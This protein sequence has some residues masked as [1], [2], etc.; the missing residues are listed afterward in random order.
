MPDPA[1][2]QQ[3][4]SGQTS[5]AAGSSLVTQVVRVMGLQGNQDARSQGLDCINRVRIE[6]NQ[7][8]WRFMKVTQSPITLA[9]GT[10]TYALDSAFRKPSFA[11]YI[12]SSGNK[13]IDLIYYD[14]AVF[15]HLNPTQQDTGDAS[16]YTL[17]NDFNDG[18]ISVYPVPDVKTA[19][20]SRLSVE[21]FARINAIADTSS[22]INLPEEAQNL[23]VIGGQAY[24]LRERDKANPTTTVAFQDYMRM[25][26][27]LLS[28]DRRQTDERPRFTIGRQ[29]IP[30]QGQL[31][32]RVV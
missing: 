6:M 17:R 11:G 27:L 18:F 15:S 14:D 5:V 12:D 13:R 1:I 25:V 26:G 31:F 4:G 32:V 19:S 3:T 7:H 21:Y 20:N 22:P 29:R 24:F 28:N 9:S 16:I 10:A 8:D 2:L 23:L 30:A